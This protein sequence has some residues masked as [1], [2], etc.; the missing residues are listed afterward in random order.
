M[1]KLLFSITLFLVT[2]LQLKAQQVPQRVQKSKWVKIM[3]DDSSY[4]F[5]EAQK[6]FQSFY[7]DYLK[8]RNKE[9]LRRERSKASPGEE[10]LESPVELL[11][12][13]YLKWSIAIKPFVRADG[14]II[15][16]SGRL[17]IIRDT[18]KQ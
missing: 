2:F 6:E 12:A 8:E 18:K 15:P 9:Q 10:H 16:L 13:D 3:S 4:N 17:A 5:L 7:S 1:R 14:S 11:V